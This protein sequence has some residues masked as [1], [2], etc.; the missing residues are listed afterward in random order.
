MS[1]GTLA[2]QI[3]SPPAWT[4]IPRQKVQR[5]CHIADCQRRTFYWTLE[6]V[7]GKPKPICKKCV[8]FR[9]V[10]EIQ[11]RSLVVATSSK[12]RKSANEIAAFADTL[13][14]EPDYSVDEEEIERQITRGR[15]T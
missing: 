15:I 2:S 12:K 1:T 13:H 8:E 6:A 10:A 9:A 11:T 14:P 3:A 4:E 5:V 7:K